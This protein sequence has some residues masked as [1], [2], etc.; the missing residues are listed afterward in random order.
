MSQT[1]RIEHFDLL[2]GFAI[3]LV[4]MGHVIA[5]CIRGLDAAFIF[6]VI[7]EVHMPIF[8]FVSGYFIYKKGFVV[9]NVV[10]RAKQ[11]LVPMVVVSALWVWYYPHSGLQSPLNF[12]IPELYCDYWKGGY[13]FTLCLFEMILIYAAL[14]KIFERVQSKGQ[15][16]TVVMLIYAAMMA[17]RFIARP[18]L[19]IDPIGIGLL[20]TYFP[21][22]MLGVVM[23]SYREETQKIFNNHVA[24][25]SCAALAIL[26]WY[27]AVYYW[28]FQMIPVW[29]SDFSQQAMTL[30]MMV[31]VMAIAQ[32][33]G[34]GENAKPSLV[35]RWFLK[36][37]RESLAIYLVHYFFLFPMPAMKEVFCGVNKSLVPLGIFSAVVAT[38]I[39]VATLGA[40]YILSQNRL[41][42]S[43]LLGKTK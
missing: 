21:V 6:K 25:F 11:L 8:F 10:K 41:T 16:V 27:H 9:P 7:K 32:N 22:F 17:W 28:E 15:R 39:I 29:V 34:R 31:P 33:I 42:A 13:W 23:S 24:V 38:G 12:T 40:V 3:F 19:T 35:R 2:K 36:L 4:V 37:G 43:I 18:E 20:S 14:C 30:F 5:I 26:C 1:N